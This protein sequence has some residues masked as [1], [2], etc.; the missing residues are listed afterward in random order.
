[1]TNA[2]SRLPR[3]YGRIKGRTLRA[4]RASLVEQQLPELSVDLSGP[5]DPQRLM[6]HAQEVWVE[7][8]FGGGEHLA[9]AELDVEDP[10][11]A[12]VAA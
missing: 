12:R 6:P 2:S 5:L 8:G 10:I 7:L 9:V 1:M 11:A 4:G 3:T